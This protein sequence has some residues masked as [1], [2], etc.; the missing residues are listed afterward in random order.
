MRRALPLALVLAT[1]LGSCG[2]TIEP[3]DLAVQMTVNRTIA[4][5][6]DTIKIVVVG[7][8]ATVVAIALNYGDNV[9]E[10]VSINGARTTTLNF[11][12]VYAAIGTYTL[13]ATVSDLGSGEKSA[14]TDIHVQ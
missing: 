7:Q 5:P 6:G 2:K 14:T 10:V 11:E 12:H 4:A 1:A 9:S 8:G 3:L 13:R